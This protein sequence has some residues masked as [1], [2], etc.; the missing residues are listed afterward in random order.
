MVRKLLDFALFYFN[1]VA[2]Q[3]QQPGCSKDS[4]P[5]PRRRT[6]NEAFSTEY[7]YTVPWSSLNRTLLSSF[8]GK[9]FSG[10]RA[11]PDDEAEFRLAIAK[12]LR[13]DYKAFKESHPGLQK[14]PGVKIYKSVAEQV[15]L[16]TLL[17]KF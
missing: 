4:N 15:I 12:K 8:E 5:Q 9:E 1:C 3:Q 16:L 6:F 7:S 13:L 11:E 10:E 17:S 2:S 14:H